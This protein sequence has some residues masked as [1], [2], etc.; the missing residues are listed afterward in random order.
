MTSEGGARRLFQL[1]SGALRR[2]IAKATDQ[3]PDGRIDDID[4]EESKDQH[5]AKEMKSESET[6]MRTKTKTQSEA[7]TE[8]IT[9]D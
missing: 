2:R 4:S 9:T 6:K 3:Q 8:T 7:Q 5:Y 1:A